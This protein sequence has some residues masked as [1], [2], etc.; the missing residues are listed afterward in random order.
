MRLRKCRL[1]GQWYHVGTS[2]SVHRDSV[3]HL[4]Q[5]DLATADCKVRNVNTHIHC[6]L[7]ITDTQSTDFCTLDSFFT[8]CHSNHVTRDFL[9][10]WVPPA[11]DSDAVESQWSDSYTGS[12]TLTHS[13]ALRRVPIFTGSAPHACRDIWCVG[14]W[15]LL[16]LTSPL[17][18][19]YS[20]TPHFLC[21]LLSPLISLLLSV[22]SSPLSTRQMVF[23]HK[24]YSHQ[25]FLCTIKLLF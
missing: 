9:P 18:S 1:T 3:S 2:V 6:Q 8:G 17:H 13:H 10:G 20:E 12:Q 16:V 23:N 4:A 14:P 5:L 25:D 21:L 22:F 15:R 24:L 7:T 11:A 19:T